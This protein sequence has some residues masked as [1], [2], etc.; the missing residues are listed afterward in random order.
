MIH[1]AYLIPS[2]IAGFVICA[3][4]IYFIARIGGEIESR[5]ER[6][7]KTAADLFIGNDAGKNLPK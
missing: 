3:T 4:L 6:M 1:W 5:I 7:T 2:F